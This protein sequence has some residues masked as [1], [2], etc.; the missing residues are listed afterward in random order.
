MIRKFT[1]L[2]R[3]PGMSREDFLR[4]CAGR[5]AAGAVSDPAFAR[6]AESHH[7]SE[8]QPQV[9]G[10]TPEPIWD[11][12]EETLIR[13]EH[14]TPDTLRDDPLH[15]LDALPAHV[16]PDQV[17]QFFARP[18]VVL[19]GPARGIRILSLPRRRPG[20]SPDEFSRH[21][22]EVHGTLVAGN[23]AFTTHCNRYVQ[24][25][26]LPGT[27]KATGGFVP[28]DGTSEFWFDSIDKAR[29]AWDDP[30]YLRDLRADEKNF[31]GSPPSH[32]LLVIVVPG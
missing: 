32:R 1:Y 13:P 16:D 25:H 11:A 27:V 31:V 8:V 24:H 26:V 6:I 28:Y 19:D 20:L 23:P 15:R 30:S 14:A 22:G 9:E 17:V 29:A 5:H 4:A 12:V 3:R 2:R 10:F 7:R 18:R 21:Y